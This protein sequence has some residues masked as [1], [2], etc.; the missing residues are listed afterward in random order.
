MDS[1]ENN[2]IC[3]MN[4][5]G[6]YLE[7][8]YIIQGFQ[9]N[10]ENKKGSFREGTDPN[11]HNW[12]IKMKADYG[13]I[14][15]I[16][17]ADK[18]EL[19]VY[20][21]DNSESQLVFIVHQNNPDTGKFDEDKIMLGF[22]SKEQAKKLYLSQYDKKGFL[23]SID[24]LTINEFREKV[25][26][27]KY[28]GKKIKKAGEFKVMNIN[29]ISD[30]LLEDLQKAKKYE[31]GQVSE[32]TGKKKVAE[33][34]WEDVKQDKT[35][36]EE[37][38]EKKTEKKE[39]EKK[40]ETDNP[41]EKLTQTA[42]RV[43]KEKAKEILDSLKESGVDT[44]NPEVQDAVIQGIEQEMQG[45]D[46]SKIAKGL[47]DKFKTS[48]D[49]KT[50]KMANSIADT[51]IDKLKQMFTNPEDVPISGSKEVGSR[52]RNVSNRAGEKDKKSVKKDYE[53]NKESPAEKKKEEKKTQKEPEKRDDI[54]SIATGN[55]IGMKKK[56]AKQFSEWAEKNNKLPD[57]NKS[58]EEKVKQTLQAVREYKKQK[59][60]LKKSL[61][62]KD[63]KKIIAFIMKE[64]NINDD[65][66][67]KYAESLG[68]DPEEAEEFV[69]KFVRKIKKSKDE[70][71]GGLADE[72]TCEQIAKKHK[73]PLADIM[74]EL[75]K[76]TKIEMEHTDRKRHAREIA[77]D[78]LVE[79]PVYYTELEKME[80]KMEKSNELKY[81][82]I[83]FIESNENI[84]SKAILIEC[85]F[86]K[87][88][89]EI[90]PVEFQKSFNKKL[91]EEIIYIK[92]NKL[93]KSEE[94]S[95]RKNILRKEYYKSINEKEKITKSDIE[96]S[97]QY[98]MS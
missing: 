3:Q 2:K 26:S 18:E 88:L 79:S 22:S 61:D 36:K 77:K 14:E 74:K 23:G 48:E 89:G 31:V 19:D 33:G 87:N 30:L 8:K 56:E 82:I 51:V 57:K 49:K 69:Y 64:K 25:S 68:I 35:K 4:N 46:S 17:G 63:E 24:K 70:M 95:D 72:M 90:I 15:G 5:E 52:L 34:K 98:I 97:Y 91:S 93:E 43:S 6:Y 13:N 38:E 86:L 28:E 16:T 37:P 27:G 42:D 10:V 65:S 58:E 96:K 67:H 39:E 81:K 1:Q 50:K 12:K 84:F 62:E 32:A 60:Q 85:E 44:S 75:E 76:G 59:G 53:K 92:K 71:E 21:G 9:I 20:I 11:G 47:A 78:H 40:T 83:P 41:N 55:T 66:F 45:I 29:E 80:K 73:V 54:I 7:D 94:L